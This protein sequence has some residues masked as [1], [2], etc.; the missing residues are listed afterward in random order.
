[1]ICMDC[2]KI[3]H[4][5]RSYKKGGREFYE[6]ENKTEMEKSGCI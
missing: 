1:M 5:Y 6:T 3:L 2:C 4:Y